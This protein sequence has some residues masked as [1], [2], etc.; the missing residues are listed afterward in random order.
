MI[1]IARELM[2]LLVFVFVVDM[3]RRGLDGG[4]KDATP[5]KKT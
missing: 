3:M 2:C 1:N 4:S 5:Q